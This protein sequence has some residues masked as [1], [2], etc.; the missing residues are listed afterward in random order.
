MIQPYV[1]DAY[2]EVSSFP[3][4]ALRPVVMENRSWVGWVIATRQ[5]EKRHGLATLNGRLSA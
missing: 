5:R 3:A 4:T 1:H 2:N